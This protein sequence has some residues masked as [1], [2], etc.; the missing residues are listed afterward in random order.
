M[1]TYFTYFL[2]TGKGIKR[3]WYI[4][5]LSVHNSLYPI[6]RNLKLIFFTKEACEEAITKLIQT[7]GGTYLT[8]LPV[9]GM[10]KGTQKNKKRKSLKGTFYRSRH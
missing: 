3:E 1:K 9:V 2:R 10:R 8:E 5:E 4:E 6:H 7:E